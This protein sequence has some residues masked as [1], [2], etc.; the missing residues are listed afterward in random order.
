MA[1]ITVAKGMGALKAN[2]DN[3]DY[4]V[5]TDHPGVLTNDFFVNLLDM[6][7]TGTP[8]DSKSFK[9]VKAGSDTSRKKFKCPGIA[10]AAAYPL[11]VVVR[12]T[13]EGVKVQMLNVMYRMKM[14]FE[15]AGKWAF[16]K[17]MGMPG[18]LHDEVKKQI[19]A[20]LG[21]E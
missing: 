3:A 2:W 14:Y 11:E 15:D 21:M 20:G 9:I 16:M 5:L 6:G 7:T 19:Q 1:G 17:N 12:K 13:E 10:H 4:G 8:M 18:S